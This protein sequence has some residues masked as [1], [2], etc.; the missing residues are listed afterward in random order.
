MQAAAALELVDQ[1]LKLDPNFALAW[2]HKARLTLFLRLD[3]RRNGAELQAA[4]EAAARRAV[5]LEPDSA[6]AHALMANAA[7]MRGDW[8]A[9]EAKYREAFA[10]GDPAE[11]GG[12]YGLLQLVVGHVYE[13]RERLLLQRQRDPLNDSAV[14]FLAAAEDSL[15]NTQGALAEYE[16]GLPLFGPWFAGYYNMVL[17]RAGSPTRLGVKTRE[18]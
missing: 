17:T 7:S 12:G 9:A 4:A 6:V 3:P 5:E 14:A 10:R 13:A 8:L 1:A 15:G 2:A 11:R 18:P 16:R